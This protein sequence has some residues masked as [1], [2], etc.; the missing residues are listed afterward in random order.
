MDGNVNFTPDE[1]VGI[2]MIVG[3]L[4]LLVGYLVGEAMALSRPGS[5]KAIAGAVSVLPEQSDE[6]RAEFV[7]ALKHRLHTEHDRRDPTDKDH[8]P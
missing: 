8:L 3:S 5:D 2:C 4:C 6:V 1:L 7:D